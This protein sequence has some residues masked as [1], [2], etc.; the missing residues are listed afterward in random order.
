[1]M[2]FFCSNAAILPHLALIS[3]FG[4]TALNVCILDR[5][6]QNRRVR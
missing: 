1:M 4:P 5:P 3:C 2:F 6:Y